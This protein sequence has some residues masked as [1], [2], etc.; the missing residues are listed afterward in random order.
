MVMRDDEWD[1]MH[2]WG[3]ESSLRMSRYQ[4][5]MIVRGFDLL[6]EGGVM[7]YSTCTYSPLENEAVVQYL[8]DNR[9]TAILEKTEISGI[10][11]APGIT[12]WEDK[13]FSTEMS[14]TARIYPHYLDSW[15]FFMARIRKS[16]KPD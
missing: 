3:T 4:K 16:A 1:L 10:K 15:G 2:S 6:K 8:L 13:E 9:E 14:R 7:V 11:T 5:Q 12:S